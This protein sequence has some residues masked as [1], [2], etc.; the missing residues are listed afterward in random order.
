MATCQRAVLT[1]AVLVVCCRPARGQGDVPVVTCVNPVAGFSIR[2]PA[3]WTMGTGILKDST[4]GI[5]NPLY[6]S[7]AGPLVSFSYLPTLPSEAAPVLA[8][9][10]LLAQEEPGGGKRMDEGVGDLR[11]CQR[12]RLRRTRHG[13]KRA[14]GNDDA[15]VC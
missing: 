2:V 15:P 8:Q 12:T 3:D 4:L 1:A 5:N 14:R 9:S 10:S 6:P 13:P 11:A 7:F